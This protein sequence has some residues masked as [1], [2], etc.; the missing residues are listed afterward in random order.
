MKQLQRCIDMN[1]ESLGWTKFYQDIILN[2]IRW[3]ELCCTE[4]GT[5]YPFINI[6]LMFLCWIRCP[7]PPTSHS[8][9]N[10][11]DRWWVSIQ[12]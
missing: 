12:R 1:G 7:L 10:D 4:G 2:T 11:R 8:S 5:P 6:S 9:H 3:T